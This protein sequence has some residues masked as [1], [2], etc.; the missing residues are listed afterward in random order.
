MLNDTKLTWVFCRNEAP[1]VTLQILRNLASVRRFDMAVMFMSSSEKK[2][3]C[4][5]LAALSFN[6]FLSDS[7]PY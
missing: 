6:T 1:D 3:W 5:C 7:P 2:G 4:I